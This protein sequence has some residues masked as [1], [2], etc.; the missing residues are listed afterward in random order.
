MAKVRFPP[1]FIR[2]EKLD[3]LIGF[4][5]SSELYRA[6]PVR[7]LILKSL[8]TSDIIGFQAYSFSRHFMSACTRILGLT[9]ND[10]GNEFSKNFLVINFFLGIECD[11]GHFVT[12]E[13]I[14]VG[15]DA[16]QCL[17]SLQ[18]LT[19]EKHPTAKSNL[20]NRKIR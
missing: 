8:V 4:F 12:C 15:I 6:L 14:P 3:F 5:F 1:L 11:N 17:S 2:F 9:A 20:C 7:D 10:R 16:N 18:V 19:S 13:V